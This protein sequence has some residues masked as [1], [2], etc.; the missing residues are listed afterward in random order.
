MYTSILY[1]NYIQYTSNR[2]RQQM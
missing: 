2:C 1:N